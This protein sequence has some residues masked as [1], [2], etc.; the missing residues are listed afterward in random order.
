MKLHL[1]DIEVYLPQTARPLFRI[2]E[3]SVPSGAKVLIQ[4]PSGKGKTTLLHLIAGLFLPSR[5][6][7]HVGEHELT[8][9]SDPQRSHLRRQKFGV[10]FQKLNLL[11]HLTALENVK[12]GL[13]RSDRE[14]EQSLNQMKMSEKKHQL[15]AT[16]SLGE[17]QRVAV[18][19]VIASRPDLILADE[20]TSSLDDANTSAVMHA[21]KSVSAKATL[22]VVSH[23]H[24]ISSEFSQVLRFEDLVRT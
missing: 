22:V 8:A 20:P 2:A 15:T 23:D 14:A 21:L 5:G 16:L 3:F 17:Q 10:I 19:R 4:G 7:I 11:D 1:S 6:K 24:R 13:H 9:M 18:A 12:L